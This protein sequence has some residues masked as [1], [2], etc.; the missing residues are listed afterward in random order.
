MPSGKCAIR[1]YIL[2]VRM[3]L[4]TVEEEED[5][6]ID[7]CYFVC[8]LFAP[9]YTA[10]NRCLLLLSTLYHSIPTYFPYF[11][12]T[13]LCV[14]CLVCMYIRVCMFVCVRM[15]VGACVYV[16]MYILRFTLPIYSLQCT[17]NQEMCN[18]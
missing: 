3:C 16:Y 8:M 10:F 5:E 12:C 18:L 17:G 1:L 15:C 14:Y 7:M 11:Q 6:E 2:Y 13:Q 4:M 9:N